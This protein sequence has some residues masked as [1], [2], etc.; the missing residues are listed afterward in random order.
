MAE[1]KSYYQIKGEYN[2]ILGRITIVII[3][4]YVEREE[5]CFFFMRFMVKTCPGSS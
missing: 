1:I 2:Y 5:F 4:D 3:N